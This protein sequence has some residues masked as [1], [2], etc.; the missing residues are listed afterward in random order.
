MKKRYVL[1]VVIILAM[2]MTA[3]SFESK[4]GAANGGTVDSSEPSETDAARSDEKEASDAVEISQGDPIIVIVDR[5]E[6]NII[7]ARDIDDEAIIYYFSTEDAEVIEGD[8]PITAGDIV[9]ITYQGVQGDEEHP[10]TAVKVV[11]EAMMYQ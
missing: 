6:D 10:G 7:V 2:G 3:C 5:Y 11:A 8:S 9:E 4:E 1:A